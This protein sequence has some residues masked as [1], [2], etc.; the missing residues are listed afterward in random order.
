MTLRTLFNKTIF[1]TV[2]ALIGP[3]CLL[4]CNAKAKRY[5][6]KHKQFIVISNHSDG[7]DPVYIICSL[8][9]YVRF[10]MS[11]HIARTPIVKFILKNL[12]G[13]IIKQRDNPSAMIDEMFASIKDE[14][15]LGLYAEGALTPNGETGF[16]SPRTGQLVK[17]MGIALI[18]YRVTGGYFHTPKWGTGLRRG[19]VTAEVVNE[20]SPEE[21]K[22]LTAEEVNEIIK[23]DIYVN[24]F[25]EQRKRPR[26]YK[27]KN[28]A[29]H[30]ERILY[31]CPHCKQVGTLHS[32]GHFLACE[33]GYEVEFGTDGFFHQRKK[34]LIF[35]NVLD[36]DK[37]QKPI[38][39]ERVLSAK[40]DE[41]IFEESGQIISTVKKY[42]KISLSDNATLRLYK[43]RFEIVLNESET[44]K[45]PIDSLKLVLNVS[46]ESL[47]LIDNT[48]YLYVKTH[49]PR[50]AAKYVA[51]WRYL[52]G[53][54]YK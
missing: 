1:N 14:V 24:A 31:M 29:E 53:K 25:E 2:R 43:D 23:R 9:K 18:T 10:V 47:L 38:W 40:K 48:N 37:W 21:L 30:I 26:I 6:P 19:P 5:R 16:F 54:D 11:D 36:W 42:K 17:D 45:L 15:S 35:D 12:A 50:A 7:L 3:P 13:W 4:I 22:Y 27:G 51:A 8:K 44:I 20:Y 52:I 34:E 46:V 33:C 39:R 28:L 32:H 49:I 41:L